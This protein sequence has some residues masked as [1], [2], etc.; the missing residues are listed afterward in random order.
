MF[1]AKWRFSLSTGTCL[2]SKCWFITRFLAVWWPRYWITP[3]HVFD[4]HLKLTW[5]VVPLETTSIDIFVLKTF[6]LNKV[7]ARSRSWL[8]SFAWSF[9]STVR[10]EPG[11]FRLRSE[12]AENCATRSDIYRSLKS[13]RCFTSVCYVFPVPRGRCSK[14]IYRVFCHIIFVSFCWMTN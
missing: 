7:L 13:W 3:C 12:R 6:I 8:I 14:T 4:F 10:V 5:T 1:Y 9:L 11:T 2:V